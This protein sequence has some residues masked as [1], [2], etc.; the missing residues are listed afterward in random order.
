MV[1]VED[2][3][4]VI[5]Q[6][7]DLRVKRQEVVVVYHDGLRVDKLHCLRDYQSRDDSKNTLS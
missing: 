4:G 2:L 1:E 7:D 5:T 3:I 6:V